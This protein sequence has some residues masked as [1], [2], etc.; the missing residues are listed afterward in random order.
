MSTGWQRTE[1]AGLPAFVGN[2]PGPVTA[3]FVFRVGQADETLAT[4]GLTHLVEHLALGHVTPLDFVSG[5]VDLWTTRAFVEREKDADVVRRL[6]EFAEGFARPPVDRL[7]AER[8]ILGVEGSDDLPYMGSMML[9]RFFGAR[10]PGLPFYDE[11]GLVDCPPAAVRDHAAWWF[12][13]ANAALVCTRKVEGLGALPLPPGEPRRVPPATALPLSLP[14]ELEDGIHMAVGGIVESPAA[15][16]LHALLWRS[17]HRTVRQEH[18]L[19]YSV[20]STIYLVGPQRGLHF[21]NTDATGAGAVKA[22][23]LV[24]E[25]IRRLAAG[26]LSADEVDV[27]KADVARLHA[28]SPTVGPRA[29]A[30]RE[31]G[32][33]RP[34]VPYDTEA[35]SAAVTIDQVVEAAAQLRDGMLVVVPAETTTGLLPPYEVKADAPVAGSRHLRV[36]VAREGFRALVVGRDGVTAEHFDGGADT[37]HFATCAAALRQTDGALALVGEDGVTVRVDEHDF[38]QGREALVAV[39][40]ALDPQLFVPTEGSTR[41]QDADERERRRQQPTPPAGA[42]SSS[43]TSTATSPTTFT[44]TGWARDP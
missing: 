24:V 12:T 34:D 36:G 6:E 21:L 10:G 20:K 9:R 30:V 7:D 22:A 42:S 13:A 19:A 44:G 26:D 5:A 35:V 16:V 14:C 1:I 38:V 2:A 31:L 33:G 11:H 29:A 15:R 41:A 25:D 3:G 32:W 43:S 18:G 40:G 8:R 23:R 28:W 37:V 39:E 27:A 4:R 17:A